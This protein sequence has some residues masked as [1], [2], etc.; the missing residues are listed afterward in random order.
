MM[1]QSVSADGRDP[2]TPMTVIERSHIMYLSVQIFITPI[3]GMAF[4]WK[5]EGGGKQKVMVGGTRSHFSLVRHMLRTP[6]CDFAKNL[7][8]RSIFFYS[9]YFLF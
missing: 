7:M 2:V 8:I 3:A 1:T 4:F 9:K 5:I 6:L